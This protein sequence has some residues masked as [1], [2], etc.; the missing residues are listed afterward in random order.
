MVNLAS[1]E[2]N[3]ELTK[4]FQFFNDWKNYFVISC[5]MMVYA[6]VLPNK[7]LFLDSYQND[8]ARNAYQQ[9]RD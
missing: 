4:K 3:R 1:F 8:S 6:C 9:H 7:T 2:S 5:L